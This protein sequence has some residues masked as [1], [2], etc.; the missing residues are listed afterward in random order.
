M[1]SFR[2]GAY[3]TGRRLRTA[4]R[5]PRRAMAVVRRDARRY[6]PGVRHA[7]FRSAG[8]IRRL[9]SDEVFEKTYTSGPESSEALDNEVL[10]RKV[11]ESE[12]WLVPIVRAGD[13][14]IALPRLPDDRRL[15]RLAP[16]L[17]GEERLSVARQAVRVAF[18]IFRHGY[19]HRDF[20][21]QNMFWIDGRLLLIDFEGLAAYPPG[22][23]PAFPQSYDLTGAG[24]PSP[25]NTK[26][27]CYASG[28]PKSLEVVLGISL[29]E[30]LDAHVADLLAEGK[31][32]SRT[33]KRGTGRHHC[34]VERI[35][36][37]F[38]VPHFRVP[39]E[40]AQRATE[41][42]F[43]EFGITGDGLSGQTVL[44]LGSNTG[45]VLFEAWRRGAASGLGVEYDV[46]KV[47]WSEKV[48]AYAGI[49]DAVRFRRADVDTLTAEEVGSFDVVFCLA[50]ERHV[51]DSG[52]L[53]ALL[54]RVC[55]RELFFEGN[56]TTDM[57]RVESL[58]R[59]AGFPRVRRL[60]PSR[61]DVLER[62]QT[63][64]LL[65]ASKDDATRPGR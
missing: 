29:E 32:V 54:G 43:R 53:L 24:L 30:A 65:V 56:S 61:A 12:P 4:I 49:G 52:A 44:D 38:D 10:A 42:R 40:E 16:H 59:D 6:M 20:H 34:A 21:T 13:R 23:R 27:A 41:D 64:E 48:A 7:G 9:G 25:F 11:F 39:P 3:R 58:L 8:R 22:T 62:N 31:A 63:R 57:A 50:I 35:Y 26:N 28:H 51:R 2:Q 47:R 1:S 17:S 45:G 60:G 19:A 33:F 5:S 18:D 55:R 14:T 37:S 15:D 36:A 46:D